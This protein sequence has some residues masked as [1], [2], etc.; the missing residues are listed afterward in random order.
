MLTRVELNNCQSGLNGLIRYQTRFND[1]R[2]K[3]GTDEELKLS[4]DIESHYAVILLLSGRDCTY[5]KD[6]LG[7]ATVQLIN[8]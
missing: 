2:A 8:C 5:I 7:A 4:A 1:C 3:M 6:I